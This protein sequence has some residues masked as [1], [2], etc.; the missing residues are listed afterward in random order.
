MVMYFT[1][2]RE[3]YIKFCNT[4]NEVLSSFQKMADNVAMQ[5]GTAFIYV[6]DN[7]YGIAVGCME[8][9]NQ[10]IGMAMMM[11]IKGMLDS[12]GLGNIAKDLN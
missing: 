9:E 12:L 10:K 8:S 1:Q 5:G 6:L 2:N 7:D 4:L 11:T 3:D